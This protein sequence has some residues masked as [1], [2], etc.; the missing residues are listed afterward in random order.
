M[1]VGADSHG[2][3][4][5]VCCRRELCSRPGPDP[6]DRS[7]AEPAPTADRSGVGWRRELCSRPGPDR[8]GDVS[9]RR[10]EPRRAPSLP[11]RTSSD[12]YPL[13][14]SGLPRMTWLVAGSSVKLVIPQVLSRN[15]HLRLR[16]GTL[17]SIPGF[18]CQPAKSTREGSRNND[19][20][21]DDPPQGGR[22]RFTAFPF[23]PDVS[24]RTDA[25]QSEEKSQDWP[26][27]RPDESPARRLSAR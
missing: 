10:P 25:S 5:G 6:T 20:A 22:N 7:P 2:R 1:I 11:G 9:R 27:H 26:G 17:G 3:S 18:P 15:S 21:A 14:T 16:D 12:R 4:V 19:D 23:P 8:I 24:R 13:E